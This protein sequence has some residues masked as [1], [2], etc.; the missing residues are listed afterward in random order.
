MPGGAI[1][2]TRLPIR[3]PPGADEQTLH[4]HAHQSMTAHGMSA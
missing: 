1:D 2:R 4:E 3:R